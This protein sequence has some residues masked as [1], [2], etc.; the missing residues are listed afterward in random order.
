MEQRLVEAGL[1][2]LGDDEEAVRRLFERPRGLGFGEAVHARFGVFQPVVRVLHRAG[3]GDERL[4]RALLLLEV[5]IEHALVAH[6]ME[7]RSR[8]DHRLGLAA[9]AVGDLVRE[10]VDHD[11]DLLLDHELVEG[12]ER[13]EQ[14]VRLVAVVVGVVLDRLQQAPVVVVGGVVL[15]HVEDEASPRWP[16]ACCRG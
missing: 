7:A 16:G 6:G 11:G 2:L 3:E 8:D 1:E 12:D 15:Q 10:V 14:V 4:E 13:A 5:G 9:D